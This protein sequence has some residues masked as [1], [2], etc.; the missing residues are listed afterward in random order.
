V[1]ALEKVLIIVAGMPG[2]GKTT[3]ANYLSDKLQIPLICKDRL[4]EI[5]W[6]YD[7]SET[8]KYGVLAYDLSFHFCEMLMKSYQNIIFE[9]NFGNACPDI[10]KAMIGK[11]GYKVITILFDGNVEVIHKRFVERDI[12]EE[13]HGGLVSNGKFDD[14]IFFKEATQPCREFDYGDIKIIVDTTDFSKVSYDDIIAKIINI[15]SNITNH[16]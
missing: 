14:F 5:I 3:F 11:Y 8:R 4:K 1:L 2:A 16:G 12:T 6:D 10:L 13:R 9:S 7:A 15:E